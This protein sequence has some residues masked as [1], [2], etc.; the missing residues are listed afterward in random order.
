MRWA[1]HTSLLYTMMLFLTALDV[2]GQNCDDEQLSLG[3]QLVKE[4]GDADLAEQAIARADSVLAAIPAQTDV[5]CPVRL[6]I[7]FHKGN[8]LELANLIEEALILYYDLIRDAESMDLHKLTAET[9]LSVARAHETIGR[10]ENCLR[11]LQKAK[12]LIEQYELLDTYSRFGVRYGSYHRLYDDRDSARHYAS[13][14]H[15]YG[16]KYGRERSELDGSLLMGILADTITE[17]S[18]YFR[19][20][21]R[22]YLRR[23]SYEGAATQYNNLTSKFL[24]I[25]ELDSARFWLDSAF[26]YA[27]KFK[28]STPEQYY[29]MSRLYDARRLIYYIAG[30]IDSAYRYLDLSRVTEQRSRTDRS[31]SAIDERET[32]FAI[33]QEQQKL[34]LAKER[35]KFLSI[36]LIFGIG[37]SALLAILLINNRRKRRQIS[38]QSDLIANQN[39]QLSSSVDR[40]KLLLH[41]IHHRVKNNLQLIISMLA[42]QGRQSEE[43]NTRVQLEQMSNRVRSIS[44]IHEQLYQTKDLENLHLPTYFDRLA[45]HFSNLPGENEPFRFEQDIPDIELNLETLMPMGLICAELIGNSIKYAQT[46]DKDLVLNLRIEKRASSDSDK[47]MYNF[48]YRDNGSGYPAGSLFNQTSSMGTTLINSMLRQLRAKG[49]SYN[50]EGAVF[51]VNFE[52]KVVSSV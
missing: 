22:V 44:L 7:L 15:E 27:A 14:G 29:T 33:E 16:K 48:I 5:I 17:A 23:G 51:E 46:E 50:D 2:Y 12:K 21:V 32:A 8:A 35:E 31:E 9:Y 10:P 37:I 18:K 20:A 43:Q 42:L 40:Q 19:A 28:A 1:Y 49:R 6:E 3:L 41:E 4:A 26:Y 24:A 11:Y 34:A 45:N 13:I 38:E 47:S 52:E 39:A 30:N 36:G 25:Q